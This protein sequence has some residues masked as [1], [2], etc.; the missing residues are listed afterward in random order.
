MTTVERTMSSTSTKL[1]ARSSA[2]STTSSMRKQNR[3]HFAKYYSDLCHIQHSHPLSVIK[4]NLDKG[5]L[6]F[7]CDR[8]K[9][10]EWWSIINALSCDKTLHFVA[11]RSRHP[12]RQTLETADTELK[13]RGVTKQPVVTTRFVLLWLTEAL[14]MCL[15]QSSTLTVLE[16]EGLPLLGD[17]LT[18]LTQGL[19]HTT[20]LQHL[21]LSRCPIRD[22]GAEIICQAIRNL[23]SIL[24]L[25]LSYCGL[26]EKGAEIIAGLIKYQKLNRYSEAWKQTLRYRDPDVEAMP[27]LRRITL[28]SNPNLGDEGINILVEEIKDDLWLRALD[29][30]DCGLTDV[31]GRILVDLLE[32][33]G[34]LVI[35]DGRANAFMNEEVLLEIMNQLALNNQNKNDT[36]YKWIN[37][38][39]DLNKRKTQRLNARLRPWTGRS[40][41]HL[42]NKVPPPSEY[43]S[44]VTTTRPPFLK[45]SNTTLNND[46]FWKKKQQT[47]FDK[48]KDNSKSNENERLRLQ[49]RDLTLLLSQEVSHKLALMEENKA[50]KE[51]LEKEE[52]EKKKLAEAQNSK[53]HLEDDTLKV[54]EKTINRFGMYLEQKNK[55]KDIEENESEVT[56]ARSTEE[57]DLPE[58]VSNLQVILKKAA[59]STDQSFEKKKSYKKHKEKARQSKSEIRSTATRDNKLFID[60]KVGDHISEENA[61]D[62]HRM[63]LEKNRRTQWLKNRAKDQ[64]IWEEE[65]TSS[66]CGDHK[67]K[68]QIANKEKSKA[69]AMF[70]KL[71]EERQENRDNFSSKNYNVGFETLNSH[72]E[73]SSD[74]SDYDSKSTENLKNQMSSNDDNSS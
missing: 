23:P 46:S 45:R 70:F 68:K 72:D 50:L 38:N 22:E 39:P 51:L 20:S 40:S 31:G 58:L 63:I 18:S 35:V 41:T 56:T 13:A 44:G 57:K 55:E 66:N 12:Q 30:Q 15:S 61:L 24:S 74:D 19:V 43:G 49:L 69:Q 47:M 11:I 60:L 54:I 26:T 59:S 33:N 25:D 48:R 36:K 37:K 10:E 62:K 29:V 32:S 71:L 42:N 65:E 28:N 2:C 8:I 34:N 64:I 5:I 6:D 16:L 1:T 9:F 52:N 7:Y 27:G 67:S 21:S 73:I 14:K 53:L 4:Q 3:S 17:Y